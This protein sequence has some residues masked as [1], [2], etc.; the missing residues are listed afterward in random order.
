MT[1]APGSSSSRGC[2]RNLGLKQRPF[3]DGGTIGFALLSYVEA[4][5]S[6]LVLDAA[7]LSSEPGTV[8]LFEGLAMDRL[9]ASVR[10]RTVHEVGLIDLLD[11]ARAAGL[12]TD[13]ARAA[14]HQPA[15][16]DWSET[17]S[18][19]VEAAFGGAIEQARAL[20]ER[21]RVG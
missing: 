10:R 14:L 7:E 21:W 12:P 3:I 19:P 5:D 9:L 8:A 20:L 1:T 17:L 18:T 13:P 15:H 11:M 6:M 2:G 16:I 4:T